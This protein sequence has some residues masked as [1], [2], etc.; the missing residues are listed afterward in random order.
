VR[1][2]PED[3]WDPGTLGCGA[4]ASWWDAFVTWL[5]FWRVFSN[6]FTDRKSVILGVW[7]APV[8]P[9]TL[10]KGG[11]LRPPTFWEGPPAPRRRPDPKDD[12]FPILK[13]FNNF[14]ATQS[15][16]TARQCLAARLFRLLS[17][18][19]GPRAGLR[20]HLRQV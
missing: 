14:I 12:R 19:L 10:P 1:S 9:D 15:A 3:V 11:G 13:Q 7:A 8:A 2:G 6:F 17:S 20:G 16:A 4:P 5:H 18:A